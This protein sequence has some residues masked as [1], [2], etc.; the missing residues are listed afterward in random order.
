MRV[1]LTVA[2]R[3]LPASVVV[4]TTAPGPDNVPPALMIELLATPPVK[5]FS[6]P[7]L[8]TVVPKAVAPEPTDSTPPLRTFAFNVS[9]I[10]PLCKDAPLSVVVAEATNAET[11]TPLLIVSPASSNT[12]PE[13]TVTPRVVQF[14]GL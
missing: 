7:P 13:L 4:P 12:P 9:T 6:V 5:I 8:E 3:I 14:S 2:P 11:V 10:A 1:P